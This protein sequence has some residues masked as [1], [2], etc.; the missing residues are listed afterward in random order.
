VWWGAEST[1]DFSDMELTK[2]KASKSTVHLELHGY[3]AGHSHREIAIHVYLLTFP[4]VI[5]VYD[6]E[7]PPMNFA[8]SRVIRHAEGSI[9]LRSKSMLC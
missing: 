4:L 9:R 6:M 2:K 3:R 1:G 8:V 5:D 7:R